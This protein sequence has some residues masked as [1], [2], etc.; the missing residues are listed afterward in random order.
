MEH[1]HENICAFGGTEVKLK[2]GQQQQQQQWNLGDLTVNSILINADVGFRS[3]TPNH[4]TRGRAK[5]HTAQNSSH[6]PKQNPDAGWSVAAGWWRTPQ[7]RLVIGFWRGASAVNATWS[8][9]LSPRESCGL[10]RGWPRSRADLALGSR[11]LLPGPKHGRGSWPTNTASPR[12]SRHAQE[13][14]AT[15]VPGPRRLLW[16]R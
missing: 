11:I 12:H 6:L 4:L 15:Q 14:E 13:R 3:K 1:E 7:T 16:A 8:P 9:S 10:R 2:C 5:P